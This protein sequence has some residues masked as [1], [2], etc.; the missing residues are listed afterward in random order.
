[1]VTLGCLKF[2]GWQ[3]TS[4][5]LSYLPWFAK[6]QNIHFIQFLSCLLLDGKMEKTKIRLISRIFLYF[7]NKK[8]VTQTGI[9]KLKWALKASNIIIV[10]IKTNRIIFPASIYQI[11]YG[12]DCICS[13]ISRNYLHMRREKYLR[14][15][16]LILYSFP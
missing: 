12:A 3:V 9:G 7:V 2:V 5:Y 1:M 14:F 4:T 6:D 10:A 16:Y 11:N 13:T 15:F 8:K